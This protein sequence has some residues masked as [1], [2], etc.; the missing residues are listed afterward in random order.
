M[1]SA[2]IY[3]FGDFTVDTAAMRV[4]RGTEEVPLEPKS[5]RLLLYLIENPGR[6]VGKEELM[7]AIWQNTFVGDN[8]LTRA[9]AQ[10]RKSLGDDAKHGRY[11]ETVPKLGYRFIVAPEKDG[12]QPVTVVANPRRSPIVW[13]SLVATALVAGGIAAWSL[14]PKVKPP[15]EPLTAVPLTSYRGTQDVPSFSPDGNQ[16]AFQWNGE[17]QDNFDIYVKGLS[18][19]ST[20]LRLTTDP[21]ADIDPAWSPDGRTIA[22]QR[23][24]GANQVDLMLIPALGGAERRLAEFAFRIPMTGINPAWSVNS[25]WLVVPVL[26]GDK[27]ALFR[28]SVESGEATQ[29]TYPENTQED[30]FPAISPDGATLLFTRRRAYTSGDLYQVR[31]DG[32]AKPVER[33]RRIPSGTA[34]FYAGLWTAD[35]KEIVACTRR[36]VLRI[37]VKGSENP[38]LIPLGPDVNSIDVSRRGDRMAYSVVRGDA[39]VWRIELSSDGVAAKARRPERLIASTFRDV[40]PQYSPDGR[41]I[42]FYSNRSGSAQVW[43]SDAEG[44]QARQLTFVPQGQVGSPRW[45]PDGRTLAVGSNTTGSFQIYTIS[46]DGGKLKQLTQGPSFNFIATWSRDGRWIY[47]SSNRTGRNEIW[48]MP[49]DGGAAVQVTRNGGQKALESPDGKILYFN[50]DVGAGSIWRMPVTGGREVQLTESLY[51]TNFE[52]AGRGIYYVTAP[53]DDWTAVLKFYSFA[54]GASATILPIG[55]P[56]YGLDVSPDGRYLIYDQLDDPASNLMLVENFR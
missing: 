7:Q 9:V 44:R 52:V 1:E 32:N 41:R 22:F 2:R 54:S 36:G 18:S 42:A 39:N 23:V 26:L 11:I 34:V 43:I 45:S 21:A 55:R 46:A 40:Y 15:A 14:R 4:F 53:G 49:A 33:P 3:R 50:K 6:V 5:L 13:A 51:R 12:R 27:V 35:G 30:G 56:E 19:D 24:K 31:I 25:N 37:P 17:G 20:P 29:I 48:K 38:E 8:S 10:I 16:V 47:F 28:V